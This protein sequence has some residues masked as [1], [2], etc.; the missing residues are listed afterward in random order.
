MESMND[1]LEK[2]Y[3][4]KDCTD[5]KQ[6]YKMYNRKGCTDVKQQVQMGNVPQIAKDCVFYAH[7]LF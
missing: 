3:N 4:W 7:H 5:V 6:R 1:R 2:I